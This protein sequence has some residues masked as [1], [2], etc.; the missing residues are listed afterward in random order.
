MP[1]FIFS[2]INTSSLSY[3]I[4]TS[5]ST[6]TNKLGFNS[7]MPLLKLQI[8]VVCEYKSQV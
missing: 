2:L 8:A 1:R 5:M 7:T 4:K 3:E 6:K